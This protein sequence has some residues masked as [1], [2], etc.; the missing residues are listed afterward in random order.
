M[1][2]VSSHI[3][4]MI[5]IGAVIKT[6]VSGQLYFS[7][8]H[9][10]PAGYQGHS[11]DYLVVNDNESG[12]HFTGIEKIAQDLEDF[13]FAGGGGA[14]E[15]SSLTDTPSE[16][17]N[18]SGKY[19]VV[20]DEED[21]VHFTPAG[22]LLSLASLEG[23]DN[24]SNLHLQSDTNNNSS[25]FQDLSINNFP[26]GALNAKH[27]TTTT[28]IYGSSSILFDGDGSISI[29][30]A[31]DFAVFSNKFISNFTIQAYIKPIL[32][33]GSTMPILG[34]A[35]QITDHG[36]RFYINT[37]NKLVFDICKGLGSQTS[38]TV[39]SSESIIENQWQ[40]V[41]IVNEN[42]NLTLYIDGSN[43]GSTAWTED[44]T[45]VNPQIPL[46]IGS[47]P[48]GNNSS[49][50]YFNG[51]MQDVRIDRTAFN[52]TYFPPTEITNSICNP[53]KLDIGFTSL[54]DAPIN[55]TN[56]AGKYVRVSDNE[57]ELEFVG[58]SIAGSTNNQFSNSFLTSDITSDGIINE[59]NF[60]GLIPGKTY[61][62]SSTVCF[63]ADNLSDLPRVDFY[64]YD[65]KMFSLFSKGSTATASNSML[66]I[67]RGDEVY[68]SGKN[69][70]SS[71]YIMGQD[72]ISFTQLELPPS[73]VVELEEEVIPPIGQP[74]DGIFS[75][76][77]MNTSLTVE[78]VGSLDLLESILSDDLTSDNIFEIT[79]C[80]TNVA[81]MATGDNARL[82]PIENI[83]QKFS[84]LEFNIDSMKV[85][86]NIDTQSPEGLSSILPFNDFE[87]IEISQ[88]CTQLTLEGLSK[89]QNLSTI[90]PA[91][92]V[93]TINS[94]NTT[95]HLEDIGTQE[96]KSSIFPQPNYPS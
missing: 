52:P 22:D 79:N 35:G 74:G 18:Q 68:A 78:D 62:I 73:V 48:L 61:R 85:Q 9:D 27:S 51:Y 20:N 89:G 86:A 54:T 60:G 63:N 14:S 94:F 88:L 8:L 80:N 95:I 12:I 72:E 40:H 53:P 76:S 33:D 19:V 77:S 92:S 67:A 7:G 6:Y 96:N 17:T 26:I 44:G 93:L 57:S 31:S 87:K 65:R 81:I 45:S 13:G 29:G 69:L 50:N 49:L 1:S 59:F 11:G 34:N 28:P 66:F 91:F 21:G 24:C 84:E 90:H 23:Y 71:A 2:K 41:A 30:A 43:V 82:I 32:L 38:V 4:S 46:Q 56:A 47:L 75:V 42:N 55:Y 36:F 5:D 70:S 10:T 58:I 64:N 83:V 25:T 3:Q 39:T 16:Y 37:N 15:F